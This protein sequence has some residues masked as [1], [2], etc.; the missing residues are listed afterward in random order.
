MSQADGFQQLQ[1][2]VSG[3][4]DTQLEALQDIQ[5]AIAETSKPVEG[6]KGG[7]RILAETTIPFPPFQGGD[8]VVFRLVDDKGKETGRE[9]FG[10]RNADGTI[11]IVATPTVAGELK[12]FASPFRGWW[13]RNI[14][15]ATTTTPAG[16]LIAYIKRNN[17]GGGKASASSASSEAGTASTVAYGKETGGMGLMAKA[18]NGRIKVQKI[19]RGVAYEPEPNY[20]Q[21]GKYVINMPQLKER[22][23]LNVKFPSLGRIPQFKPVPISDVFK[24]F[25]LDLLE[26]GKT[27]NRIYDQIPIEE[28]QLFER[29]A[30]G[31]GLIHSLKIKKTVT[32]DD[33]VDNER[34]A[35]L[36]GEYLAGNNSVAL[37]KELRKLVVKFMGQGKISKTD[38]L[39]L[40]VELSV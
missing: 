21:F 4:S 7:Q 1:N 28:R 2:A 8:A 23:I 17:T 25:L 26:T 35:I 27:S 11:T 39:N 22:D 9:Q 24:E 13:E 32:D 16:D 6:V 36:K 12:K 14:G 30:T 3:I 31:A 10:R 38:G 40:L 19:G 18:K 5:N 20:R 15:S 34:F 33:K 29:I 37:M